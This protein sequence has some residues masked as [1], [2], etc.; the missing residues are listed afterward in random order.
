MDMHYLLTVVLPAIIVVVLGFGI[1]RLLT[2]LITRFGAK[3]ELSAAQS[4]RMKAIARWSLVVLVVFIVAG[5][6]GLGLSNIWLTI[7]TLAVTILIGFFAMWNI[8][9][10]L[11]SFAI[12]ILTRQFDVGDRVTILPENISGEAVYIGV[13]HTKLQTEDRD[14]IFI[15]NITFPTRF[16]QVSRT[17]GFER[18]N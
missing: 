15:P 4:Y 2:L 5:I 3:H 12:I 14:R 18:P 9:S 16:T 6:F 13:I 1:E 11:L 10:N 17:K 8:L 7:S